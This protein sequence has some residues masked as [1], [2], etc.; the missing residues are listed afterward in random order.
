MIGDGVIH[1]EKA[2]KDFPSHWLIAHE[3]AHQW[4]GNL[5]T[6]R[7]WS[8]TWLNESFATYSEYLYAKQSLGND[9]GALNLRGKTGQY[10]AE[11][12]EKYQ[13]PIVFDRWNVPNDNFDRHTYQKGAV[14]LSMLRWVMGDE[15]FRR[16]IAYYLKKHAFQSVDTHDF[17][18]AIREST[19]QVLDW[20]FEEWIYQ[21]GHPVFDIGY[22]WSGESGKVL[23]KV[24]QTQES[25]GRIPIFRMP[26]LIGITTAPG[27]RTHRIWISQRE[28]TFELECAEKP[29]SVRFDDGNHLLK[30]VRFPVPSGELLYQLAHGDAIAR[31]EA[32]S[33]LSQS[34]DR[35]TTAA[36]QRAAREDKFWAVRRDAILALGSRPGSVDRVF[37]QEIDA[38]PVSA[39]RVAAL[40][41][42]GDRQEGSLVPYFE[43]RFKAED[44]YLAQA[45][46]PRSIGKCGGRSSASLPRS[47]VL[48]KS[49]GNVLRDAA[50]AALRELER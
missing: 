47:A 8:Q 13:R 10:L 38:D 2:D 30:E 5:V 12:R 41:V 22:Q 1:D 45:E 27:K 32:A 15:P 14:V 36:L 37:L 3:A 31:L 17:V 50:T 24:V 42:L 46:A 26:V 44:S 29:L 48:L 18:L 35:S 34:S 28:E 19:G 43:S 4:W 11:S 7:D 21:A 23:L 9:E 16:A 20:F 25:P 33:E 49:P 6:M 40:R 39:V